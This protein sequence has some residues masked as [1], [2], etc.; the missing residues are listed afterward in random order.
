MADTSQCD[1]SKQSCACNYECNPSVR[2]YFVPFTPGDGTTPQSCHDE[3]VTVCSQIPS[4]NIFGALTSSCNPSKQAC[5]CQVS[6]QNG[7][8]NYALVPAGPGYSGPQFKS[9]KQCQD[10]IHVTC[11]SGPSQQTWMN[12]IVAGLYTPF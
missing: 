12:S 3:A 10:S 11:P 1:P 7:H 5:A 2:S 4:P 8:A 9:L 6:C